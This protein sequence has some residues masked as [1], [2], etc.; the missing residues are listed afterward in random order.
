MELPNPCIKYYLKGTEDHV[1]GI[2]NVFLDEPAIFCKYF[3]CEKIMRIWLRSLV[4]EGDLF[5]VLDVSN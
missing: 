4:S 1:K 5:Y 2:P 3:L